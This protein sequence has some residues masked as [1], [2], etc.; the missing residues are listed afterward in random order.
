MT[1]V[2]EPCTF[3]KLTSD[4]REAVDL[5]FTDHANGLLFIKETHNPSQVFNISSTKKLRLYSFSGLETQQFSLKMVDTENYVIMNRGE[6]LEFDQKTSYIL[7]KPCTHSD[8]QLF[9]IKESWSENE[10]VYPY[11]NKYYEN[12]FRHLEPETSYHYLSE[13]TYQT[14]NPVTNTTR[15][16]YA[17]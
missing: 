6:C 2:T 8:Y 14:R 17:Y 9:T 4:I 15:S 13:P 12:N 16:R 7:L 10:D 11:D 3:V 5:T 1:L